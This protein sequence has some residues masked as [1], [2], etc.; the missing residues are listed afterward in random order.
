MKLQAEG[1]IVIDRQMG[2]QGIV[3]EDHGDVSVLWFHI[4]HIL[5]VDAEL[6]GSDV[7]KS[8]NHAKSRGFPAA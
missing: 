1:H 4:V 2:V 8:R 3:L 7:L 5:A 6:T